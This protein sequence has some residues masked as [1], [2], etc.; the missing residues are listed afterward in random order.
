MSILYAMIVLLT[1]Q[2]QAG[3]QEVPRAACE[4]AAAGFVAHKIEDPTVASV[5]ATCVPEGSAA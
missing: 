4:L 2:V 3:Y 5:I 1:G